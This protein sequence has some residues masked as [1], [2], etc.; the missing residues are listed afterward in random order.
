MAED[1]LIVAPK[2]GMEARCRFRYNADMKLIL[3]IGVL[4]L[5]LAAGAAGIVPSC[6]LYRVE[7]RTAGGDW[8]AAVVHPALVAKPKGCFS[9]PATVA[10]AS[11][12]SVFPVEIRVTPKAPFAAA[13]IRPRSR[14][15]FGA[16]DGES[17]VFTL[18]RPENLVVDFD[19]AI[20]GNLCLFVSGARDLALAG[21]D[22]LVFGPGLHHLPKEGLFVPSGKRVVIDDDAWLDGSLIVSNV[23][24]VAIEGHGVV[25]PLENYREHGIRIAHAQR[26]T[27]R[28]PV[29]NQ[30]SV[31]GSEDVTIEN[32]K[33]LT[34]Y[35][36]G[37]GF[38]IFAASNVTYR[39]IFARTSDDCQTVYATRKGFTG[40]ARNIRVEGAVLWADIAHPIM[41]G[42]HG[43]A[44]GQDIIEDLIYRDIDILDQHENQ[45]E[46]QGCM[47]VNCGDNNLVRRVRFED[48]RIEDLRKGSL[49][50]LRV[51]WNAK[52]CRAPGGGIDDVLF[53]DVTYT[54]RT[55]AYSIIA[56][57]DE[58]RRVSN[59]RFENLVLN[60][61]RV[62]D[63]MAAK[64]KWYVTTDMAGIYVG[65]HADVPVFR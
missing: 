33:A 23:T 47:T 5:S 46:Y 61:V 3:G 9:E 36:W 7:S 44:D 54:G 49:L 18:T 30:C 14:G 34:H 2:R 38:N 57:Y 6:D 19:G 31:G 28:G 63:A 29:V 35:G 17:Y 40:G 58:M 4:A 59:V 27:V 12:A 25:R 15:L 60:G 1:V 56:G 8:C 45:I 42:I 22:D 52:Y 65:S 48:I 43:N 26:V 50:Q 39:T 64:P 24:D 51:G 20:Y 41:I 37:D 11:V 55:P 16:K 62:C 10:F 53:K 13:E 21:K 32:V